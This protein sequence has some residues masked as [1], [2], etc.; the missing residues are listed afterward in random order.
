MKKATDNGK[1][2]RDGCIRGDYHE[3]TSVTRENE[4]FSFAVRAERN[5]SRIAKIPRDN[6]GMINELS[7]RQVSLQF[8]LPTHRRK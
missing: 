3:I 8:H 7:L 1:K 4:A 5:K 6:L 2:E